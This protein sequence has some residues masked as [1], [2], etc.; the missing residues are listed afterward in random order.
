MPGAP[1]DALGVIPAATSG[2]LIVSFPVRD[3]MRNRPFPDDPG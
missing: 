2:R 3:L 1:V